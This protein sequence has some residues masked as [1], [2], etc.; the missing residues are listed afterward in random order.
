MNDLRAAMPP[1]FEKE[2]DPMATK[3][4]RAADATHNMIPVFLQRLPDEGGVSEV[5]QRVTVTV[6]SVNTILPRGEMIYVTPEQYEVLYNSNR[7]EHM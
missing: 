7:F 1:A 3:T 5:D 6:N 2:D 4:T